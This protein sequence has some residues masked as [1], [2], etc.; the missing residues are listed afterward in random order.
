MPIELS[1]ASAHARENDEGMHEMEALSHPARGEI[2]I[3]E[4]LKALAE[5]VRL[6]IVRYLSRNGPCACSSIDVGLTK[7]NLAHH[8]RTLRDAGI[9]KTEPNGRFRVSSLRREDL[10]ARFPGLLDG[11]LAGLKG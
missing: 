11:V 2:D 7:Q 3:Q 8:L 4:V 1:R 9:V 6:D 10:D 5:P